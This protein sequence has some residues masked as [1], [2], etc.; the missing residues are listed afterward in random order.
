MK[1][2][3][4]NGIGNLKISYF[5]REDVRSKPSWRFPTSIE[6]VR[7]HLFL[8]YTNLLSF[9]RCKF[10]LITWYRNSFCAAQICQT[11]QDEIFFRSWMTMGLMSLKI[12]SQH[13]HGHKNFMNGIFRFLMQDGAILLSFVD[14]GLH[15]GIYQFMSLSVK[16]DKWF[17]EMPIWEDSWSMVTAPKTYRGVYRSS[18]HCNILFLTSKLNFV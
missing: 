15:N 6:W 12:V 4:H 18:A 10:L 16:T 11:L 5:L 14:F 7:P 8:S 17:L 13:F 3:I 9:P 2:V 1:E